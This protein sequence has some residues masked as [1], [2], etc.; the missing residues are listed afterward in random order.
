MSDSP[1]FDLPVSGANGFRSPAYDPPSSEGTPSRETL[2]GETLPGGALP[3]ETLFCETLSCGARA[4][5]YAAADAGS[6][7]RVVGGSAPWR[8]HARRPGGARRGPQRLGATLRIGIALA[9]VGFAL[10]CSSSSGD[11]E[12]GPDPNAP[13]QPSTEAV[14]F[15]DAHAGMQR[16][17]NR[18]ADLSSGA[19]GLHAIADELEG[20][21]LSRAAD[22]QQWVRAS[23]DFERTLLALEDSVAAAALAAVEMADHEAA[24]QQMRIDALAA[25]TGE[26][27]QQPKLISLA[28][29][30]V[31]T[32][33]AITLTRVYRNIRD[34][35]HRNQNLP[36]RRVA[37]GSTEGRQAIVDALSR[38]GVDVP[39]GATGE[40][41]ADL[42]EQQSS[43]SLRTHVTQTARDFNLT[44]SG[45]DGA[46]ALA[47][48]ENMEVQRQQNAQAARDGGV[49]AVDSVVNLSTAGPTGLG[50]AGEATMLVLT[51]TE[52]TPNDY[53]NRHV[54]AVVAS[55]QTQPLQTSAP[56][57]DPDTA[58]NRLRDAADGG[59]MQPTPAEAEAFVESLVAALRAQAERFAPLTA[60][61]MRIAFGST[62]LAPAGVG[63]FEANMTVPGLRDGDTADILLS[64]EDALAQETSNHVLGASSPLALRH[65]PLL[66]TLTLSATPTGPAV[67]D[68]RGW[69]AEAVVRS[70]PEPTTLVFDGV[71]VVVT[72]RV[73]PAVQ[74]DAFT[75]QVDAYGSATLR[76]R[77]LDTGESYLIALTADDDEQ[78]ECPGVGTFACDN[79]EVICA[80]LACNGS[81]NC[82]DGSDED[83]AMCGSE[84]S[85][86][87]ATRG[88]PSETGSTCGETCCCCPY[89]QICDPTDFRRGCVAE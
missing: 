37:T 48:T 78:D 62:T 70:V 2:P 55:R 80:D 1:A 24:L 56:T 33:T 23:A 64:R 14:A 52:R 9:A 20:L 12:P 26:F 66:G 67:D 82:S 36:V 61:P 43:R 34:L 5:G 58:R 18:I 75:V 79:G 77:R 41:V 22:R 10:A 7:G 63:A 44:T 13:N 40:Q 21:D 17:M 3:V 83:N 42:F 8:S 19:R 69:S 87:V 65:T 76:V 57:V 28:T 39:A 60:L 71:N 68:V 59:D 88:C 32:T 51:A 86:C 16:T 89:G 35:S 29:V 84:D 30:L 74:A 49:I 53:V 85:C 72:P 81:A 15:N 27:A 47:A 25:S 6:S 31:V 45:G 73:V 11:P 4:D 38:Q 46:A 50:T 54:D